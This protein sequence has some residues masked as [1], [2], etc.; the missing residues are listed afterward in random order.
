LEAAGRRLDE[1]L[2]RARIVMPCL[3]RTP[4]TLGWHEH[5]LITPLTR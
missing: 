1:E 5:G 4:G 2:T 3:G